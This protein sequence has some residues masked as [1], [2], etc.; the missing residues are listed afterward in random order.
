MGANTNDPGFRAPVSPDGDFCFLPIPEREPTT[1][2][3]PTYGD[4]APDLSCPVPDRVADTPVH[5][6]PSFAGYPRCEAYTYGDPHGVKARPILDLAAGDRLY[7][8]AT[9]SVTGPA[10]DLPPDWGAFLIGH[11]TLAID[12]IPGDALDTVSAADLAMV[13]DNAH[14]RRARMD[15]RVLVAGDP[16]GSG[17]YERAVPL[18]A[19][20]GGTD[21]A[22]LVTVHSADSGRGPWWRR[23]LRFRGADA[24]ALARRVDPVCK[25]QA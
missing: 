15:A 23:P 17:R 18:S 14:F 21:P 2:P 10:P 12:P 20:T 13:A 1:A 11:F 3:V 22:D 25:Y 16:A 4:L 19:P 9:L 24:R 6:D 8:Y 5:L 7:F